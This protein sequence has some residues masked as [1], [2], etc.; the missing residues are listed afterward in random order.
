MHISI[1]TFERLPRAARGGMVVYAPDIDGDAS[2]I[3]T[4]A[5]VAAP[6]AGGG[7]GVW[8]PPRSPWL[9]QGEAG[10]LHTAKIV[11]FLKRGVNSAL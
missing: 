4:K 11:R 5:A 10:P 6:E 3:V 2:H 1:L 9:R 8:Q 7:V